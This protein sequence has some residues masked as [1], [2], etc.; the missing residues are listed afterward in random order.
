ML[1]QIVGVSAS[2]HA[3]FTPSMTNELRLLGIIATDQS[4]I[5]PT[6]DAAALV[7]QAVRSGQLT[8]VLANN[9]DLTLK[10]AISAAL[11]ITM[12]KSPQMTEQLANWYKAQRQDA[13]SGTASKAVLPLGSTVFPNKYGT[14]SAFAVTS[15]NKVVIML[16]SDASQMIPVFLDSVLPYLAQICNKSV[17][18]HTIQTYGLKPNELQ[19]KL[20][21]LLKS[22]NPIVAFYPTGLNA[23][24]RTVAVADNQTS[25]QHSAAIAAKTVAAKLG[26]SVCDLDTEAGLEN[27]LVKQFSQKNLTCAVAEIS[28]TRQLINRLSEVKGVGK[29]VKTAYPFQSLSTAIQNLGIRPGQISSGQTTASDAITVAEAARQNSGAQLGLALISPQNFRQDEKITVAITDGKNSWTKRF[30][31]NSSLSTEY[32]LNFCS[33]ELI[34]LAIKIASVL[35]KIYPG[36]T[37]ISPSLNRNYAALDS[38]SSSSSTLAPIGSTAVA[39]KNRTDTKS[40][41]AKP[42]YKKLASNIIPLKGDDSITI[43]RK[44]ILIVSIL[45]FTGSISYLANNKLNSV[46]TKNM[47][48]GLSEQLYDP[49]TDPNYVPPSDYP[50]DY[51]I[52]FAKLW[53]DNPDII[54]YLNIPD[55]T[56]NYPVVHTT[57]K[58]NSGENYYHRR[59][60]TKA[61]NAHGTPYADYESDIKKPSTNIIVYGHNMTDGQMF[62]EVDRYKT[63]SFYQQHPIIDFDSVYKNGRY[64]IFGVFITNTLPQHGEVFNYQRF[65]N[66]KDQAEFNSFVTEVKARSLYNIPVDVKYG[67]ELLTLSTCNYYYNGVRMFEE[68]RL[69]VIARRVRDNE[70]IDVDVVNTVMNP[71]PKLPDEWYKVMSNA[72]I[73]ADE[74]ITSITIGGDRE[75]TMKIGETAALTSTIVPS[76]A[77][78]KKVLWTSSNADAVTVDEN[79]NI[80]A[81]G[82]GTAAVTVTTV[83]GGEK[84]D[85]IKIIVDA[86]AKPPME[87]LN[88]NKNTINLII[89]KSETLTAVISPKGAEAKV[90][91][92][93]S[94]TDNLQIVEDSKNP[95]KITLTAKSPANGI[96]ITAYTEDGAF[97]DECEVNI[98]ADGIL[99][100]EIELNYS[101]LQL[102][103]KAN[104]ALHATVYPEDATKKSIKWT[105]SDDKIAK[106]NDSGRVTGV[107][108]GT[109][110]ITATSADGA[111][112]AKCTVTVGSSNV[113]VTSIS[114]PSSET[115]TVGSSRTLSPTISPSNATN[116]S[117]SWSSSN[118]SVATV[119][120]GTVKGIS[121]GSATITV[122]T[123]DGGKTASCS[124][125][126]TGGNVAVTGISLPS[127]ETV[128][129]G[130]SKTLSVTI[131][132]SNAS[133][134]GISWG[135][136]N[137]SVATVDNGTVRGVSAGTATIT[138]STV[139]GGKTASCSVT[140]TGG[141]VAVTGVSISSSASLNVGATTHLSPTISPSNAT[142]KSVSWSS[143][144]NSVATV[145]DGTI[146]GV[147]PGNA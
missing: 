61:A 103:V 95:L 139:D 108:A 44:I 29:V 101:E 14:Q 15:G 36:A 57:K 124:V 91:W 84:T 109:A 73:K 92:K 110:I 143:S 79:G 140:V 100:E 30:T 86:P 121:A 75:R 88:L 137:S 119:D 41:A 111:A 135:S 138:A 3:Y 87:G 94:D 11:G 146:R 52:K 130:S 115:I 54:G 131:S 83:A 51:Q 1:A 116:K 32:Q 104:A 6:G 46:N 18:F 31:V 42:W 144:N 58:D 106:V 72:K 93:S 40:S 23:I 17:A 126:V 4:I 128:T 65:I 81:V 96:I 102:A 147:S 66:A 85:S 63:L 13:P 89:N 112:N 35:P 90:H 129:V 125:T 99:V 25:A 82:P 107:K 27:T 56:V 53:D 74:A 10:Q 132:P 19:A 7:T 145:D 120:N 117:V 59:D 16:P 60:F 9:I 33:D 2:R 24:V 141:T 123:V 39:V 127:S 113:A 142:N 47:Y 76:T 114:L 22:E 49:E 118:N 68:A 136:S 5:N 20:G 67:D 45:V 38:V 105:S 26:D 122:S 21:S 43:L 78:N 134:K 8:F 50:K 133:N 34:H 12:V 48:E 64:K 97:Y 62:G 55:T 37:P 98:T 28:P 77:T 80:K 69:V 70:N 71:N